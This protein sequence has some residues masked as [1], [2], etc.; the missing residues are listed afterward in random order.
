MEITGILA[1][2]KQKLVVPSCLAWGR[3]SCRAL[4]CLDSGLCP[5][6]NGLPYFAI[7][8]NSR[9]CVFNCTDIEA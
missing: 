4:L 9:G 3:A 2:E 6:V 1:Q 8:A 5:R 7:T